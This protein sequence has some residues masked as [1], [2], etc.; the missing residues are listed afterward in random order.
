LVAML[1]L[2]NMELAWWEAGA[3]FALWFVQFAFSAIPP[4]VKF[5]GAI[6]G[7][8]HLWVT[9]V[10]FIWAAWELLRLLLGRR[11]PAAFTEFGKLW[12]T[13]V[14]VSLQ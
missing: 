6:A 8:A 9:V 11:K 10:Y 4:E 1:F 5:W 13:H 3:L 7:R 12:R 2:V 14:S